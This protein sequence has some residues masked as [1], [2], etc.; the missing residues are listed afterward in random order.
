VC[1]SYPKLPF[2]V[3]ASA[4]LKMSLSSIIVIRFWAKYLAEKYLVDD[5]FSRKHQVENQREYVSF[6][7]LVLIREFEVGSP[8]WLTTFWKFS[9]F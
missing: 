9:C 6:L 8:T 3:I 5:G 4:S 1:V 7:C 2:K